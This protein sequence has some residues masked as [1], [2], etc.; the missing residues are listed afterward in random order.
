MY[1]YVYIYMC[2]CGRDLSVLFG[3]PDFYITCR[4]TY[5]F[6]CVWDFVALFGGFSSFSSGAYSFKVRHLKTDQLA[7]RFV[8][9]STLVTNTAQAQRTI[10]VI[11]VNTVRMGILKRMWWWSALLF[12]IYKQRCQTCGM[13]SAHDWFPFLQVFMGSPGMTFMQ[14]LCLMCNHA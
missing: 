14:C 5:I 2:V 12:Q 4:N 3:A 10:V 9:H 8:C 11:S 7:D 13:R 6:I 1:I